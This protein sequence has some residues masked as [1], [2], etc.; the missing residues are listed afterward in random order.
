MKKL[1]LNLI[2]CAIPICGFL[3]GVGDYSGWWDNMSGRNLA[4][5][6]V[7][8]LISGKGY[9]NSWIYKN[10]SDY[11]ALKQIIDR[12][13]IN[14]EL[15][16]RRAN[17]LEPS[18]I[19]IVPITRTKAI[20]PDSWPDFYFTP[21]TSPVV[22][23]YGENIYGDNP[24]NLN[25]THPKGD[26]SIWI[27]KLSDLPRWIDSSRN[28]ERFWVTTIMLGSVGILLAFLQFE[29]REATGSLANSTKNPNH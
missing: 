13:S 9:P 16:K 18:L 29:R 4:Q 15:N 19:T 5:K 26:D 8:R 3:Y 21:S 28:S 1:I 27:G 10:D 14:I 17:G 2:A 24:F 23:M 22:Y 20:T 12:Y 11:L 25:P 7:D 6:A